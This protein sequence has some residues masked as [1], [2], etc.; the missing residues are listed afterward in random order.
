MKTCKK[1]SLEKN[2]SE[3]FTDENG[4]FKI[5]NFGLLAGVGYL[6][7]GI[8]MIGIFFF[9]SPFSNEIL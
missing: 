2:E 4:K 8:G 5:E 9:K 6:S 3:I 7:V 1:C